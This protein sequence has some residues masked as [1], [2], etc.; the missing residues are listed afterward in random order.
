MEILTALKSTSKTGSASLRAGQIRPALR[1]RLQEV[2]DHHEGRVPIHGRLFAQWLHH[3]Y[4]H[5]CS[6]PHMSG[7]KHPL[8]V[9]D[10]EAETNRSSTLS[11]KE[12]ESFVANASKMS[13]VS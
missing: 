13:N 7:S 9:S 2:A 8:Y 6:Y 12:M 11:D 3:V 1:R 10:F 5:E 4:P